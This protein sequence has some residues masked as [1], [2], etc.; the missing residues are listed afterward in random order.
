MKG[1]KRHLLITLSQT[2]IFAHSKIKW[3]TLKLSINTDPLFSKM[4]NLTTLLFALLFHSSLAFKYLV[5]NPIRAPSHVNFANEIVKTLRKANHTA[6]QY[7]PVQIAGF[8]LDKLAKEHSK[9]WIRWPKKASVAENFFSRW[10]M[11]MW[12]AEGV[13]MENVIKVILSI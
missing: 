1:S 13:T 8:D 6:I 5:Y 10:A 7:S 9:N 4:A 11:G 3:S 2:H 12:D